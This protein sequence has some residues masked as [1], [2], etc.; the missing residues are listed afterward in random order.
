MWSLIKQIDEQVSMDADL[1]S[2]S[3]I[4]KALDKT[5]EDDEIDTITFGLETDDGNLV[6][7]YVKEEQADE[8][9]KAL[10]TLL[11]KEDDIEKVLNE[12]AKKFDIIN[13]EWPDEDKDKA[14]DEEDFD[15]PDSDGSES[16]T[17]FKDEVEDKNIKVKPA[18]Q[19]IKQASEGVSFGK[20]FA[21]KYLEEDGVV[22]ASNQGKEKTDADKYKDYVANQR[23]NKKAYVSMQQWLQAEEERSKKLKEAVAKI[24]LVDDEDDHKQVAGGLSFNSAPNKQLIYDLIILL[25]VPKQVITAKRIAFVKLIRNKALELGKNTRVRNMLNALRTELQEA[26]KLSEATTEIEDTIA[27]AYGKKIIALLRWL[28]VTDKEFEY[29]TTSTKQ[30]VTKIGRKFAQAPKARLILNRV[31]TILELGAIED[32]KPAK[33]T[34]K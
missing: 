4:A 16:Q 10:S 14:P 21:A 29:K 22:T 13:V 24:E 7:V 26:Q 3:G 28:G 12:L 20:M 1:S 8:F 2:A 17:K 25:G 33:P 23:K 9:E 27:N 15:T 6:K 31:L 32:D 5:V 34:K 19:G 30:S 18:S 11:G